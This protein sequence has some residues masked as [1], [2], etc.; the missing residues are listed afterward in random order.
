MLITVSKNKLK[1]VIQIVNSICPK[2]T[3]LNI[4]N[5]F[6]LEAKD[7]N[8]FIQATDLEINYQTTFPARIEKEGKILIP[9]K[10]FEKIVD[11]LFEDDLTLEVQNEILYLRG[12][13]FFV[14]LPGLLEEEYPT[15]SPINKENYFEIENSLFMDTLDKLQP[16]L[17]TSDLRPE[18][19]G[20]FFDLTT[21]GLNLVATDSFR[22]AV[23]KIKPIYYETNLE[24]L[25]VLLPLRLIKEYRGIKKKSGKLRIY[26]EESQ[27]TFETMNHILTSKLINI[28]YPNYKEYLNPSSFIFSLIIDREEVIK[29]LK[30]NSVYLSSLK[31]LDCE[32]N[33]NEKKV[34]FITRS[35]L[36]GEAKTEVDFEVK[37]SRWENSDFKVKFNFDF[38]FDGF[39]VFDADK[40]FVNFFATG[41]EVFPLYLS[42]P[43]EEDFVYISMHL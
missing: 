12:K 31:E 8:A 42:S 14:N 24:N 25:S 36:L 19:A 38:F 21:Q 41:E 20:V 29:S 26:F 4:L 10:Q 6:Y 18:F 35:E 33:F 23:Q 3:D 32:F 2:K 1:E 17:Q 16:I 28:E 40:V 37:E 34:I 7:G 9:A 22:L 27:V 30:L 15:F 5:Y 13:K 43:T 39:D 11:N